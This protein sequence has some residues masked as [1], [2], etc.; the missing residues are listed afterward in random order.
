[1]ISI[2]QALEHVIQ[3]AVPKPAQSV[4]LEKSL[5]HVLWEDVFSDLDAPPHDQSL[6]DGYAVR[7]TDFC[8]RAI[9]AQEDGGNVELEILEEVTAGNIPTCRVESGRTIRVMTGVHVP[10]G[11]DAVVMLEDVLWQR[12]AG[13]SLGVA[14]F[15]TR[16][17]VA[18]QNIMPQATSLHRGQ[19]VLPSGKRVGPVEIAVLAQVGRT[20]VR[21]F[22]RPQV[23]LLPTGDELV[24]VEFLP[25]P[26][27]IRNSNG[28]MLAACAR[29][30]GAEVLDLGIGR[31]DREQ[32]RAVLAQGLSADV[33]VISGGVSA[34]TL[35]L[36]PEVLEDL[37]VRQVFHKVNLKP[38]KPLWF[39][40]AD[41][42]QGDRE[43]GGST[44][45]FGLP[46]NPVSSFVCFQLFVSMALRRL[47]GEDLSE[48]FAPRPS[49][50]LARP[51]EVRGDRVTYAP[52]RLDWTEAGAVLE[53]VAWHGS[54]DIR[55]LVD[56]NALAIFPEGDGHYEA[57]QRILYHPL[58]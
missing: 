3:Y 44:L 5:G 30:V 37:G 2:E 36:V 39:G 26:G 57:G 22:G 51:F 40:V 46:G 28:P 43:A 33:L 55:G 11:A 10:E 14:R 6:V 52:A 13:L 50:R 1:M 48:P 54:G 21:V 53:P 42:V 34:G 15:A 45:V 47:S 7:S 29:Q 56:A 18:G 58:D 25:G 17:V 16:E 24:D 27:K 12:E 49:A 38:G 19:R 23:A 4:P 9:R 8:P 32:L 35:D 20:D 41:R 31:D